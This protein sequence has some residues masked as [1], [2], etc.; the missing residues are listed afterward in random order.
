M[1]FDRR[2]DEIRDLRFQIHDN[3]DQAAAA[4]NTNSSNANQ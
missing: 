1:V 4:A 3:C 2:R